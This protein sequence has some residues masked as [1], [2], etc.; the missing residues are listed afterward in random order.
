MLAAQSLAERTTTGHEDED[1]DE[2]DFQAQ[3]G[4]STILDKGVRLRELP[5]LVAGGRRIGAVSAADRRR[6]ETDRR[7]DVSAGGTRGH[8]P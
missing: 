2:D 1:E 4:Q 3:R 6:G 5:E 7:D 8:R